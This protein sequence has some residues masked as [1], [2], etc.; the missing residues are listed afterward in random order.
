[1]VSLWKYVGRTKQILL[2]FIFPVFLEI[3]AFVCI[4]M[5]TSKVSLKQMEATTNLSLSISL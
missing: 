4:I 5:K 3:F 1:M 2:L